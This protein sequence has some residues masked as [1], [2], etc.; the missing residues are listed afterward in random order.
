MDDSELRPSLIDFSAIGKIQAQIQNLEDQIQKIKD[1]LSQ[2][3]KMGVLVHAHLRIVPVDILLNGFTE[4]KK[5]KKSWW[6]EPFTLIQG[7][8]NG[9][10]CR[11]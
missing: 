10:V 4:K 7:L 1:S 2:I 5:E 11:L 9:T 8:Q 6:S 3:Q